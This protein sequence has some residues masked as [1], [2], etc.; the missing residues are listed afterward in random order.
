MLA[1]TF[2]WCLFFISTIHA[3]ETVVYSEGFESGDGG[4]THTGTLDVWEW[5]TPSPGF[6]LGPDAHSGSNC[7]GSDLDDNVQYESNAY[8]TS[9]PIMLPPLGPNH[10]MRVRFFG[11]IAVDF[12]ADRG[13]FQVSSDAVSWETKADL[14]LTMQGGWNEYVFDI[15]DYQGAPIYLRFRYFAD[16]VDNFDPPDIPYNMA[17]FYVDDIA[18]TIAEAPAIKSI[19]TFE[20]SEDQSS[21]AS[22]PWIFVGDKKGDFKEENDVY[23]VARGSDREYTDFYQL[24]KE[25]EANKNG[26]FVIKLKETEEEESYTDNFHLFLLDHAANI[27]VITD[28]YGN[29]FTYVKNNPQAPSTAADKNGSSVLSLISDPD[30]TGYKA[31]DTDYIDLDFSSIGSVQHPIFLLKVHG[32]QMETTPGDLTKQQ[33]KVRIQTQ[34][35]SGQWITRNLFYPR[36]KPAIAGY[37]MGGLFP[38]SKKIRLLVSSCHTGK[39]QLIDWAV[40]ATA[41]QEPVTITELAPE[42]AIRSDG[43]DVTTTLSAIDDDYVY[44]ATGQEIT[45]T[46]DEPSSANKNTRNFVVKSKGYYIPSGTYFFYTWD[47]S[48]WV[49]RDGWSIGSAGDQTRQF[50][51]SLWLPDP[52]GEYKV[53]IWQDFFFDPAAVDYVGLTHDSSDLTMEYA[54]DLRDGSSILDL[55]NLSDNQQLFWDYGEDWPYRDRW[56]EIG[57]TNEVVN[58]PPSTY[59]VFVTNTNSPMPTISWTYFDLDDDP[60][61]QYEIEVWS[62][63]DRTGSNL[64]D[65]LVEQDSVTSDIYAGISLVSG[66]R[67]YASVKAFD[68]VSWGTWSE[69]AFT[70]GS[71]YPP[72]AEAGP[73]QTVN[74]PPSCE[75]TVALDGSA[76][77]DPDGDTLSFL[78]TGPFGTITGAKPAVVLPPGTFLIK[79]IVSDSYGGTGMDSVTITVLDVTAPVPDSASLPQ[80]TGDCSVSINEPPTATDSC[81][82]MIVGTTDSLTFTTPGTYTVV[83]SYDDGN[84]NI[85]TQN[86]TVV[87]EDNLAPIPDSSSLPTLTGDCFV[88]VTEFP[89]ATDN[90][91]GMIVGTTADPLI[92]SQQGTYTITWEYIDDVGNISTQPQTVSVINTTTPVPD[93]DPLPTLT[94][95]CEIEIEEIPTATDGCVG[96]IQGTTDDPLKYTTAGTFTITWHYDNG[97]GTITTQTQTVIVIDTTPPVPD[98]GSLPEVRGDCNVKLICQ[99]PT[100]MDDCKGIIIGSTSDDLKYDTHGVYTITWTFDDG[101]GN[102]STQEQI[103]IV[104]DLDAPVP[105]VDPLPVIQGDCYVA[106]SNKPTATDNCDYQ[107][108]GQTTDTLH[109]SEEGTYTI[110]WTYTDRSGNT[111]TQPQTVIVRDIA[112][113]VPATAELP[114]V[115][116]DCKVCVSEKPVAIDDCKGQIIGKTSDPLCYSKQGTY[117]I[118][119]EYDDGNG[120]TSTQIQTVIVHDDIPPVPSVSPLPEIYGTRKWYGGYSSY[121]YSKCCKCKKKFEVKEYPTAVDNC[122]G[123]IVATTSSPLVFYYR[124]TYVI[125]W[126]YHDGNGNVTTQNQTVHVK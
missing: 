101:N 123:K 25:F 65:P 113:P 118:T 81:M 71:N 23:S 52:D 24:N 110:L 116:G 111:S 79:L 12:M 48:N 4:Y 38:Y 20:G 45:M 112:P 15:T 32:F 35:Q 49:Q 84:G 31:Y 78:W 82:G 44:M 61:T 7:W 47:G 99:S 19:L 28:E 115:Q 17:G 58:T 73:D 72:V 55:V 64:W 102:I 9:P 53:R 94:A 40:I 124:G 68:G 91:K 100:A 93:V 22:C 21:I 95:S 59:P 1:L 88:E 80:I 83:W 126:E 6:T 69:A 46:F 10:V 2:L 29:I 120:N 50:D 14:L 109:Y 39:Y 36:W 60:Q 76:S 63:P 5:G 41:P 34:N 103:V 43:L 26:K 37:D 3:A 97:N 13:Q 54:I 74:A 125:V 96:T 62:G 27:D 67:Y 114:I 18:I 106:V 107:I 89:T 70:A 121:M 75:T 66:E 108:V 119:W 104:E 98:E 11:W 16:N 57:W 56:V 92:Y 30:E 42:S 122:T 86:Q 8:L 85:A 90:C 33:P 77:Y 117:T 51:L 105:N 87:V